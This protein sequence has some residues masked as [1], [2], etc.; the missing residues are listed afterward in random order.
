[1][2]TKMI[3]LSDLVADPVGTLTECASTGDAVLVALPDD[4][5]VS[6]QGIEPGEDDSLIDDLLQSNPSFRAL[7]DRSKQSRRKEFPGET[8]T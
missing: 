8:L 4:R 5:L 6:I 3:A 7:L 1:M 2:G